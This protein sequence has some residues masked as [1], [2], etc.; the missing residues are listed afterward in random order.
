MSPTIDVAMRWLRFRNCI[1]LLV[2]SFLAGA[3]AGVIS[4]LALS[5]AIERFVIL[6]SRMPG[7]PVLSYGQ[8]AFFTATP[9][10]GMIGGAC[11]L[12][13]G[14]PWHRA[15]VAAAFLSISLGVVSAVIVQMSWFD[16][17]ESN[18]QAPIELVVFAPLMVESAVLVV[19]GT[20]FGVVVMWR[21]RNDTTN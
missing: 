17:V 13:L 8:M 18:V 15:S 14:T 3:V 11:G 19:S 5:V 7:V 6:P 12:L 9:I 4:D 16:F 10:A 21:R 1:P 2:L 20:V